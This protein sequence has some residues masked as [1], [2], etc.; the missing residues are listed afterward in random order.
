MLEVDDVT[1]LTAQ[2]AAMQNMMSTHFNNLVLGQQPAQ[3]NVVQQP[4]SWCEICEGGDHSAE[5]IRHTLCGPQSIAQWTKHSGK[6]YHQS[7]PYAYMLRE[8]NVWLKVVMNYLIPGL[9]YTDISR[10]RVCLVY[11]LM[12]SMELNIGAIVKSAM[13]KARVHKGHKYAFGGLITQMCHA[14]GVPEESLDYMAP[15][16]P[17]PVDITRT[18]GPDTEFGPTLTTVEC[19][20]RDELVM[21][22]MYGL[23]MLRHQNGCH[24][25][26]D[27]QLGE[28]ARRYPLNDHVKALLGIGPAFCEPIDNDIPTDE[29]HAHPSSDV[30]SDS[31]EEIDPVQAGDE[32]KGGDAM[33]D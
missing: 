7:L 30:D 31:E 25:S 14:A 19:H 21:A 27:L 10:D 28:V 2:I 23:E 9:H 15:L 20:R 24:A 29:E 26:T 11:A 32:A 6:R 3:V 4:P 18:K 13:R 8:T 22:R 5:A 33:E 17:A 12:T 16:C 1:A